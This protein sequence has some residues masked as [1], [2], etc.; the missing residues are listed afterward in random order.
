MVNKV[1]ELKSFLRLRGLKV[2]G[3][4]K[5]NWSGGKAICCDGK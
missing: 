5:K 3:K 2:T 1:E 4:K